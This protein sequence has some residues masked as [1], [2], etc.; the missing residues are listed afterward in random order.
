MAEVM[1]SEVGEMPDV[2]NCAIMAFENPGLSHIGEKFFKNLDFQS[3]LTC[4]LVRKSYNE[5]FKKQASKIDL[6]NVITQSK[7]CNHLLEEKNWREFLKES[8]IEVPNLILN[9][10][11]QNLLSSKK[12]DHRTPLIAFTNIGNSKIVDFILQAKTIPVTIRECSEALWIVSTEYGYVNV[13]KV[14]RRY[15]NSKAIYY[16]AIHGNLEVLKVWMDGDD[17]PCA[18]DSKRIMDHSTGCCFVNNSTIW[19]AACSGNVEVLKYFEDKFSK[20]WC[21]KALLKRDRFGVTI[22]HD[23]AEGGMA[24]GDDLEMLKYVCQKVPFRNPIEK[25]SEG[26]TPI[27]NAAYGGHLEIVNFLVSYTS[28]PNV[29]NEDGD[30][31]IHFAAEGGHLEIVKLLVSYPSNPNS[32]NKHGR[33]P[34]HFAAVGG[35]LEVVK[36]LALHISNPNV[37]DQYGYTP[38]HLAAMEG[39]F[40]VVKF[41]A[42]LTSNPNSVDMD[43][44]TPIHWAAE[45]GHLEIVNFLALY[46]STPNSPDLMGQTPSE[47]A[48]SK[49]FLDIAAF[50]LELETKKDIKSKKSF[51]KSLQ[52]HQEK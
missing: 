37:A 45:D 18:I 10:Y 9:S 42:I 43:G 13:A 44:R 25:D 22:F 52:D 15:R 12:F 46:T 11:L 48:R 47:L 5:M 35:Y 32:A 20:D 7:F 49:G 28:D 50:L 51:Q 1:N 4:R 3:K 40:E 14:L 39:H 38:I 19:A 33:T 8:R 2:N 41:L 17:E 30:T 23:L 26:R 36:F 24:E 29:A 27:H 34:I 31:P 16:A 6:K 21:E